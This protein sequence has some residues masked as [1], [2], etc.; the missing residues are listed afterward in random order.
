MGK[1]GGREEITFCFCDE[2]LLEVGGATVKENNQRSCCR[3]SNGS[4]PDS[5]S[6]KWSE[7]YMVQTLLEPK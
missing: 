1:G 7:V 6:D 3:D 5:D 2:R 4:G